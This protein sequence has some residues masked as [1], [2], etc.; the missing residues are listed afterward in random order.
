MTTSAEKYW[1]VIPAAGVGKRMQA[2]RPKQYLPLLGKSVIEHTIARF[3]RHPAIAG[4]VLAISEGDEYWAGLSLDVG[5][6][7]HVAPGGK[8][9]CDSVLNAL[10][11]LST[12]AAADDWALVHDAARP[13]LRPSDIDRLIDAC[14]GD[15]VGGILA[16]PVRD[17]M[18]RQ[19][20]AQRVACTEEREG[21][22]H[23]LTPQMFRLGELFGA[24]ETALGEKATVT[25]EASAL[26]HVGKSPLLV[27]G[28]GDNI[29]ITRPEDLAL[30]EF[31][32]HQ[33]A[34]ESR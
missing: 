28:R 1:A 19:D 32:L 29:K 31:F 20:E 2:D 7:C 4:I 3:D 8:E 34:A 10:T 33:E 15:A 12:H 16:T 5:K 11:L 14:R 27:E 23:A 30:A 26:E 17:T 9:R 22:W 25:D 18:K 24:L 21:L 13:C 6:P